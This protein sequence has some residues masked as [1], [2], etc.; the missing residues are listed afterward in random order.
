MRNAWKGHVVGKLERRI[1]S[2]IAI[3]SART[4]TQG[5]IPHAIRVDLRSPSQ[6][7]F[8]AREEQAVVVQVVYVDFKPAM[9]DLV[10]ELV[11]D[12]IPALGHDLERGLD[13][14]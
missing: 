13:P 11:G 9:S 1:P 2:G 10:D 7:S 14:R 5:M 3:E 4:E 8:V 6:E 12:W